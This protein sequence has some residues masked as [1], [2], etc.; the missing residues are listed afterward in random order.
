[1]R[2]AA[3]VMVAIVALTTCARS[4]IDAQAS[5]NLQARVDAIRAAADAG[6]IEQAQLLL[7]QLERAVSRLERRGELSASRASEI[8]DAAAS[9]T[10]A[11][12]AATSAISPSSSPLPSESPENG[13][14]GHGHDGG[15][16]GNSE[17]APGHDGD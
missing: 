12:D 13:E 10:A 15:G 14:G 2:S 9:V 1:M 17:D 7:G 3:V 4:E 16:P 5:R 8:L 11:L 6:D